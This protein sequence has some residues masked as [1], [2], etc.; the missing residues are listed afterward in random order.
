[1]SCLTSAAR[2]AL[3]RRIQQSHKT[4]VL[5]DL[6]A[7]ATHQAWPKP[8]CLIL[9]ATTDAVATMSLTLGQHHCA[10]GSLVVVV[11]AATVAAATLLV[12][13]LML[14]VKQSRLRL[15]T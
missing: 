4:G 10:D 11:V 15:L 12:C 13:I 5:V 2:E 8:R 1:M 14:L 9:T 6:L 3:G 7:R